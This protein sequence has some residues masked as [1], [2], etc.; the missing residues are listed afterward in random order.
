MPEEKIP[1]WL[2]GGFKWGNKLTPRTGDLDTLTSGLIAKGLLSPAD[3]VRRAGRGVAWAE[4]LAVAGGW[5]ALLL[6]L[7][8]VRFVTRSY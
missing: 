7:A 6:G 4:V 3:E 2:L 8:M 5:I 1:R